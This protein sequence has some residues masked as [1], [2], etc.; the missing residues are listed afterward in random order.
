MVKL[1]IVSIFMFLTLSALLHA[2]GPSSV[3]TLTKIHDVKLSD[4][5]IIIISDIICKTALATKARSD[6][7]LP[8]Q[9][10]EVISEAN[11]VRITVVPYFSRSDISG[12]CTGDATP[13][14][15]LK[16]HPKLYADNWKKN[17][18]EAKKLRT[19][20]KAT[21]GFQGEIISITGYE[22]KEIVGWGS[23]TLT[24]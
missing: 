2:G 21:I 6:N 17:I 8:T 23:L 19:G 12:V 24:Q 22:I 10:N 18:E 11:R 5:K 9:T 7:N 16:A 3:V 15:L 1:P 14:Q 4:G 20:E 13:E